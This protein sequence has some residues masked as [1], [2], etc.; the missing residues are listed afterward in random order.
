MCTQIHDYFKLTAGT[1]VK[2]K[3][4]TKQRMV[5]SGHIKAT[6]E[7]NNKHLVSADNQINILG[8]ESNQ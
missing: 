6:Q 1:K 2:K 3:K 5:S 8:F 7:N 4:Q